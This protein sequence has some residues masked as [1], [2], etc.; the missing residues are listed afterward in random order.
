MNIVKE[1]EVFAVGIEQ[2]NLIY[3]MFFAVIT[4]VRQEANIAAVSF[5]TWHQRI[6][7]LNVNSLK[8]LLSKDLVLGVTVKDAVSSFMRF[9]N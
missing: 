9:T 2:T 7:H 5:E 6:G 8:D 1:D 3:R 4:A